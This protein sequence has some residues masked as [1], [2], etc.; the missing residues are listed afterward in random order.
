MRVAWMSDFT[1]GPKYGQFT[2]KEA[3][4]SDAKDCQISAAVKIVFRIGML[5]KCYQQNL[6]TCT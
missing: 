6:V 2:S 5:G 4:V 1:Q 3:E